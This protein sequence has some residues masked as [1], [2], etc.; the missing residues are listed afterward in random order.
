[1]LYFCPFFQNAIKMKRTLLFLLSKMLLAACHTEKKVSES[2]PPQGNGGGGAAITVVSGSPAA[3]ASPKVFIYKMK[4][5]YSQNVP[6]LLSPDKK[7]IVSYPHPRDLYT[8]GKLAVPTKLNDGYW[9]D[10][11]GINE[12]VAFLSYTYEEYAALSEVPSVSE[13]YKKIVDK[14][15]VTELWD[16]GRR[17]QFQDIV[18]D[19]NEAIANGE[20]AKR[21]QRVK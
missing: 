20:L 16:C 2:T 11:R 4:K 18:S 5:D 8:N 1:M 21:F 17:H 10:N 14:N 15:P 7:T 3:V 12:N 19:L 9:L 13:L 6:V